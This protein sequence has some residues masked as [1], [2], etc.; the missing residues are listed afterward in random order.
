MAMRPGN[1]ALSSSWA[2]RRPN[3]HG[4]VT[5]SFAQSVSRDHPESDTGSD[6]GCMLP[7]TDATSH[8]H[9][10]GKEKRKKTVENSAQV[11]RV[12]VWCHSKSTKSKQLSTIGTCAH[13]VCHVALFYITEQAL[14]GRASQSRFP[15][16][17]PAAPFPAVR[18]S[19]NIPLLGPD[20][21]NLFPSHRECD[22]KAARD[23]SL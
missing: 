20:R 14:P 13:N 15:V 11:I 8:E 16:P 5:V 9:L 19:L 23:R 7:P 17:F 21:F 22:L 6:T 1:V 12:S 4:K 2:T 18:P 3:D 10:P